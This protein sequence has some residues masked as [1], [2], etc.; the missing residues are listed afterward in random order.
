MLLVL[1]LM[2][3]TYISILHSLWRQMRMYENTRLMEVQRKDYDALC[4]KMEVGRIYRH[5]M[6]HHLA[7]VEG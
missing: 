6:R 1:A 3:L 7:A 2:P 5:D 4:Q